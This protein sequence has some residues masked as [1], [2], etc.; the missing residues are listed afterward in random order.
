VDLAT[1]MN[2][3]LDDHAVGFIA[4]LVP[5]RLIGSNEAL[6]RWH[7]RGDLLSTVE[8]GTQMPT[9]IKTY[10]RDMSHYV[11][12]GG[13]SRDIPARPHYLLA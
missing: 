10:Q 1:P 5:E 8:K 4:S 6:R 7:T 9:T 12:C 3:A 11:P 13:E 2:L